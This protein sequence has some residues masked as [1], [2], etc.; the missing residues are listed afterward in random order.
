MP[1]KYKRRDLSERF[2]E[3]VDKGAADACWEWNASRNADG[4]GQIGTYREDGKH[5][6]RKAHCISYELTHNVKLEQGQHILHSCD[7]PP[8]VNPNHLRIGTNAENIADKVAKG[9]QAKQKGIEHGN[10]KL[11]D[12]KV[13]EIRKEYAAGGILQRELAEKYEISQR[14]VSAIITKKLWKHIE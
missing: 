11:T 5:V 3:K 9:R 8:C 13:R 12:E 1:K 10:A 14:T 4:Y 2:W 6:M 7:N